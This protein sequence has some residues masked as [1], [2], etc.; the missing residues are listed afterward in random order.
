MLTFAAD[1]YPAGDF[2]GL[3][4]AAQRVR[5][6]GMTVDLRVFPESA[7]E[8]GADDRR[9]DRVDPNVGRAPFDGEI[10]HQREVGGLGDAVGAELRAAF[11]SGDAGDDDHR[12]VA[13]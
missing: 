1:R 13:A 12:A 6:Y 11:E 3:A 7:R 5:L 9:C 8:V 4:D 10:A 2:V